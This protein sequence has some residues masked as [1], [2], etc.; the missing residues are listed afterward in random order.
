MLISIVF[1]TPVQFWRQYLEVDAG[2]TVAQAINLSSFATDFPEY[3]DHMPDVGIYGVLCDANRILKANDRVELYR[4]LVFDPQQTRRR[5]AE[6]KTSKAKPK[7][8]MSH[9]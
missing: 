7:T 1:A 8:K 6:H 4:P 3:T 5:R 2:T 9:S